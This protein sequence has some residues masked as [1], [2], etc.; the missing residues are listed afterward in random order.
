M[1]RHRTGHLQAH[2]NSKQ[3]TQC[4]YKLNIEARSR[5]RYCHGKTIHIA[6]SECVAVA[7]VIQHAKRM[8]RIILLSAVCLALPYFSTLSHKRHDFRK[9]VIEHKMCVFLYNVCLKH[10]SF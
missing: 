5:N 4:T 3:D 9:N 1:F 7:L 10:F 8:R 2:N 6:Y